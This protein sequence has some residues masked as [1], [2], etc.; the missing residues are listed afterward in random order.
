M[1]AS[2]T[3]TDPSGHYTTSEI[4]KI[5]ADAIA[6][7]AMWQSVLAPSSATISINIV[8]TTDTLRSDGSS[9]VSQFKQHVGGFDIDDQGAAY[10]LRN[11]IDPNGTDSD[12]TIRLNPDFQSTYYWIDPLD[13]STKPTDKN[14]LIDVLAHEMGHALA[15]NGWTDPSTYQL[16]GNYESPF[17]ALITLIDGKP[18]FTGAHAE[19][20][21][22]G[23]V[24]LT[25]GNVMHLGNNDPGPGSD[26]IS[27]LMNGVVFH[28][29]RYSIS[30][31]DVAILS[32]S[33]LATILSDN[34]LG[35]DSADTMN[36]G[37]GNDTVTSGAGNDT[38]RGGNDNDLLDGGA[39]ADRMY[40]GAGN[41]TYMIDNISDRAYETT[42]GGIDD[43]GHDLVITSVTM[44]LGAFVED[45][46]ISGSTA[47]TSGNGNSLDN[48]M[49]GDANTNILRGLD[50]ND[51][52]DGGSAGSDKLYGGAGND[53]YVLHATV[54][55]YED[56]TAG[57]DDGGTDLVIAD[58]SYTLTNFVENLTL[59]G[60][61]VS[62]YGNASNNLLRGDAVG[63]KLDGYA[64]ADTMY[65]GA[66][67]D[68]Y[69]VDNTGD[70]VS[71]QTVPGVDD[72]G[73]D[74][75]VSTVTYIKVPSGKLSVTFANSLVSSLEQTEGTPDRDARVTVVSAPF[76]VPY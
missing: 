35:S 12:I 38:I 61:A 59:M 31:L 55:V 28:F 4:A 21:Y 24:P 3:L 58:I 50:G 20:V 34:L 1:G 44:T 15:F 57:I 46:T 60:S 9:T 33:G 5:K 18:Y 45:L 6:A 54:R 42:S 64:G 49:T 13:G 8:I 56:S 74:K 16:P 68:S 75:V 27:D 29:D 32:D 25:G 53:T 17:D 62:G 41:D 26:L 10:E 73:T 70:I 47:T 76:I 40:G 11:G 52:L 7:F 37:D 23:P 66:G 69:G 71:E 22:G 36:G 30:P 51:V 14:D 72:G 48:H 19:A 67:N 43:G 2:I 65:G 63:N 39:G